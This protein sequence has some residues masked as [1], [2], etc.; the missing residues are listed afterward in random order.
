MYME[1]IPKRERTCDS[2]DLEGNWTCDVLDLD[3]VFKAMRTQ[4][5]TVRMIV[6]R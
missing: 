1:F 3:L 6:E 2:S 4:C 5:F